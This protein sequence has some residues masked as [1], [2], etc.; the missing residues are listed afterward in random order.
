[1]IE[2][3][4]RKI[5]KYHKYNLGNEN[6]DYYNETHLPEFIASITYLLEHNKALVEALEL[7]NKALKEIQDRAQYIQQERNIHDI[8]DKTL[9][10]IAALTTYKGEE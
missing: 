4:K 8:T 5:E 6:V 10:Q 1:M 3:I 9:N 2:E 7:A